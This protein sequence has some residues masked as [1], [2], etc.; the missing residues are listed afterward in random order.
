MFEKNYILHQ[1]RFCFNHYN[2]IYEDYPPLV[3][4]ASRA[5]DVGEM[6]VYVEILYN[7]NDISLNTYNNFKALLKK[8]YIKS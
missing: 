6:D 2:T 5:R 7:Q 3:R 1:I 4:T 8:M